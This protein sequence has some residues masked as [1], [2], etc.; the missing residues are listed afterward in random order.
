MGWGVGGL[1]WGPAQV[2]I[3]KPEIGQ[4]RVR[5]LW[6][7]WERE[8]GQVLNEP[9]LPPRR[10]PWATAREHKRQSEREAEKEHGLGSGR[11]DHKCLSVKKSETRG[12]PGARTPTK[13]GPPGVSRR[14]QRG[15][16][17]CKSMSVGASVCVCVGGG[18]G[19]IRRKGPQRRLGRRLEEVA[20]AVGGGYCRLQM[21]L[22]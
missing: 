22:Y 17:G 21:P 3:Q 13:K 5:E 20:K 16:K 9:P 12:W 15:H 10:R 6:G 11:K 7:V 2:P 18:E 8:G 14:V 19:C 4:W 1:E